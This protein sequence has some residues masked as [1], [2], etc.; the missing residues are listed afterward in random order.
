MNVKDFFI[1]QLDEI[2]E[3]FKSVS[4]KSEYVNDLS[5][6]SGSI[7][8]SALITK[9]LATIERIVGNNSEYYNS[10]NVAYEKKYAGDNAGRKLIYI[11]GIV[12]ALKDD[13]T[14]NYLSTLK[15]L[16]HADVF[17]DYIEMA[18]YLLS[19]GYKDPAAV[20]AGSTLE[21]HV[22][23]LCFKNSIPV[24]YENSKGKVVAK[25]ADLLNS[26]LAKNEIYNKTYQKQITAWLDLRNNAAHGKYNEYGDYEVKLMIGGLMNFIL[27]YPA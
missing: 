6:I 10:M 18:E 8:V 4:S 16:I 19:E 14:N 9:C 15:E 11:I 24:E 27:A 12:K 21:S 17:S 26:E 5:D 25:K 23:K 2:L 7:E 1:K 22:R 20:I 13:L 3:E